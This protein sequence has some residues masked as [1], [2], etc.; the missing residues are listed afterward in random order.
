MNIIRMK[1]VTGRVKQVI[2]KAD[3]RDEWKNDMTS[4]ALFSRGRELARQLDD[5]VMSQKI[6]PL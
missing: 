2:Y 5:A 3:Y 6:S 1:H 4:L